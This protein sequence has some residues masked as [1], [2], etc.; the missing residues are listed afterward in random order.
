[1]FK[2]GYTATY[3]DMDACKSHSKTCI[4][5]AL[6]SG[7]AVL[8]GFH[9]H[10]AL[11]Q[12]STASPGSRDPKA[13][14]YLAPA[15]SGR[16]TFKLPK[17]DVD[18]RFVLQSTQPIIKVNGM[19]RWALD[20]VAHASTPPCE[21]VLDSVHRN[22][23]WA[24]AKAVDT[25]GSN[26]VNT[27]AYWGKLGG[28]TDSLYVKKGEGKLQVC[29]GNIGGQLPLAGCGLRECNGL[30][31]ILCNPHLGCGSGFLLCLLQ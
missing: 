6:S 20:N 2:Q 16:E 31:K 9:A 8:S 15:A 4:C 10:Q 17:K 12:S 25:S 22:L 5:F 29:G 18:R 14:P 24:A 1:M 21:P 27:E 11:L 23:Q 7:F 26:G 28:D 3:T 19:L 30:A 13:A